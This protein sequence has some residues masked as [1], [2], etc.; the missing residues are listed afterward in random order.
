[1]KIFAVGNSFYGDDGVGVAVL[2]RIREANTFPGA[3]LFDAS[4]DAL[5]LLDKFTPGELNVIIDAAEMG[6]EPGEVA[7]FKPDEVKVKI[8]SDHL[9]MHGFG[10]GET[11]QMAERLGTMPEKVLIVGVQPARIEINQG[12]SEPVKA[13]LPRIISLIEAEATA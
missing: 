4:T 2:E 3:E 12:L 1:M 5:A 8:Q 11:F 9:S 13:A 7:A 10:L 6:L